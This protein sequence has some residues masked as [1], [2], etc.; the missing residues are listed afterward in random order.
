MCARLSLALALCTLNKAKSSELRLQRVGGKS[1][2]EIVVNRSL[3][4]TV[5]K[6]KGQN[7]LAISSC[8]APDSKGGES[9]TELVVSSTEHK[10]QLRTR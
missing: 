6:R 4:S 2:T 8:T 3:S 1:E 10:D 7:L 5:A 9:E